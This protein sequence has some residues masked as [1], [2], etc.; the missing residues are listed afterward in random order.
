MKGGAGRSNREPRAA[1]PVAA[2]G[3][4][5]AAGL[6]GAVGL[7]MVYAVEG[8]VSRPHALAG[9]LVACVNAAAA[10]GINARA[11][12]RARSEAPLW[13]VAANGL[14]WLVML[15][16]LIGYFVVFPTGFA[17]FGLMAAAALLAFVGAE[18]VH[19]HRRG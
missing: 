15:S 16:I 1:F 9:W 3:Y 12:S 5:A 8:V 2:L 10:R 7:A 14:R 11:V 19:L 18:V 13:G 6:G 17:A 4:A